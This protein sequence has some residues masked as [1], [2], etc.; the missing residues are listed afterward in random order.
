M[1]FPIHFRGTVASMP[2]CVPMGLGLN[3]ESEVSLQ[4]TQVFIF[5]SGVVDKWVL[6]EGKL[7]QSQI[8]HWYVPRVMLHSVEAQMASGLEMSTAAA[9]QRF[10]LSK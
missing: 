5:T 1:E 9:W 7:F 8:S 10:V 6:K 2:G 4:V 3:P